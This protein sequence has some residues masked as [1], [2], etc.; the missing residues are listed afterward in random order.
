MIESRFWSIFEEKVVPDKQD[1]TEGNKT[2]TK[3][4]GQQDYRL[5]YNASKTITKAREEPEQNRENASYNA[6]PLKT[7]LQTKTLTE[8][9]EENDQDESNRNFFS[10]PQTHKS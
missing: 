8:A 7:D 5:M 1:S 2:L 4:Q 9:R 10:I 6:L 3:Q